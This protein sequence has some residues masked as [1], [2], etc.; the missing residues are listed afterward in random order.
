MIRY[1][2][3]GCGMMGQEH[4]RNILL[5]DQTQISCLADTDAGMLAQASELAGKKARCFVDY[6][7]LLSAA[8]FDALVVATPNHT[9]API[10]TDV[11][12]GGL[13]V[14]VLVE[15]PLC[16]NSQQCR[17]ITE[18]ARVSAQPVWVA[19]EYRYMPPVARLLEAVG[20]GAAGRLHMVSIREHRYPFLAK[21]G[22]WNRFNENTGGTLVE[23]C[24]HFFDLFSLIVGSE[25]TRIY[26][27]AAMSVNHLEE[28]YQGRT[29]DIIDN[30]YVIVDFEN[31]V[32][33]MLD[34][35]MFAEGT[36]WQEQITVSGDQQTLELFVPGP[37]TFAPNSRGRE[38]KI[39]SYPRNAK[40][41]SEQTIEVD[42]ALLRAGHHHGASFY[43]HQKFRQLVLGEAAVEVSLHDGFRAVAMG[44]AAQL[45]AQKGCAVDLT[46]WMN[47]T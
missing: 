46:D 19:M 38:A 36:V 31:G 4:I 7:D 22:D 14:P 34:L 21:V 18:Q 8:A 33:A 23:K 25:P 37:D 20:D 41:H 9:H 29:P 24:C 26:A 6:R 3:I 47:Q 5:C 2:V 32:R 28:S 17:A 30:A 16:I 42:A 35:C 13:A 12:S 10:M 45:S 39:V 43:Q 15:K 27:S 11:L 1:G 40:P 44:E